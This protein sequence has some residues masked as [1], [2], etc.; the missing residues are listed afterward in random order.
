V[1]FY[2]VLAGVDSNL[3]GSKA[4]P[5]TVTNGRVAFGASLDVAKKLPKNPGSWNDGIE[6]VRKDIVNIATFNPVLTGA[7]LGL[8]GGPVG[9]A[10]GAT[11]GL[12]IVGIDKLT[13]G[14]ATKLLQAG[15]KNVR[16]NY[17]FVRDVADKN[18]GMGLLTG[19][20]MIAG[21]VLG[22]LVG[23]IAGPEGTAIGAAFGVGLTG[24][25]ER[26]LFES[27]AGADISKTLNKS[28]KFAGTEA[29]QVKYNFGR[30][31]TR[32]VLAKVPGWN[33]LGD[34]TKGIG[35]VTSGAL[36]FGF[37]VTL[38][39]D[40][41]AGKGVGL[42]ARKTMIRPITEPMT[43]LTRAV[44]SESE[45]S[46]V[47]QR[48]MADVDMIKRT[49][50]GEQTPYT[51]VF[52][53]YQE[54]KPHELASRKE[55]DSEIGQVAAQLFAGKSTEEIGLLARVGRGDVEAVSEMAQKHADT[56]AEMARY[57]D[58]L[59]AVDKDGIINFQY[60]GNLIP[61][62]KRFQENYDMVQAEMDSL[63]AKTKW[64]GD[65]LELEGAM[66]NRTVSRWAW[67]ER[68]RN[69][70]AKE[71]AAR[72]VSGTAD[73][74]PE[75]GIGKSYQWAYQKSPFSAFIR[76]VD[77]VTQDAPN[78]VVNFNDTVIANERVAASLRQAE[79]V[80]A[81]IPENNLRIFDK[82][83]RATNESEK[84]AIL[85]EYTATGFKM[86]G[87]KHGIAPMLID[88]AIK[89]Y[90][91]NHRLFQS[92][93]MKA[94]NMKKGYMNDPQNPNTLISDPQL[95]TQLANGAM[96]MDWELADKALKEFKDHH[97]AAATIP[98]RV[99]DSSRIMA[100]EL[101]GLWR[102]FT[103]LRTGYPVNVIKDAH[104]RAWGDAALFDVW[105]YLGQDAIDAVTNSS[106]TINRVNRWAVGKID[107]NKNMQY[108]REEITARQNTL[109]ILGGY[110]KKAGL[111]VN[112][113]P[114]K[115]PAKFIEDLENYN[116]IQA[117]LDGLRVHE[118][119]IVKGIKP[120][121]V[122]RQTI[123]ID[124]ETFEA[125]GAG[126]FGQ[127]FMSKITQKDDL[128]RAMSSI[129]ELAI[130]NA[131]RGRSGTRTVLPTDE[132]LHL[133]SWEQILNDKIRF[134]PVAR[135]IMDNTSDVTIVKWLKSPEGFDYM[136]R[137]AAKR[138]DAPEIYDR[139][140]A[141]V[142]MYAPSQAMRKL[143]MEDKMSAVELKKLYP[144]INER[145]PVY[146]DMADDMLGTSGF[147]KEGRQKIKDAIATLSTWPTSKL[148][149]S[150]YFRAKYEQQLQSQIW[151]ANAQDK[152]LTIADKARFE[153]R[154][155]EFAL[156]EYREKLNSFHRDMNYSGVTNYLLAFFPA[157][158]E[159]FRAYGRIT[160]EHPEFAI[161]KLKF[162]ATPEQISDV[163]T[164]P[165]GN[166]Y[167]EVDLPYFGLKSRI[168]T[169]W[170]N[171]D[172]PTG[173]DLISIHPFAG[174]A[175][176]EFV[177]RSHIENRF[178]DMVLP[179]GVQSN[180]LNAATPNTI[181]R[182]SQVFSAGFSKD[183]EQFNKDVKMFDDQL[184][185]EFS[186]THDG[187]QP[188]SSDWADIHRQAQKNAFY[189]SVLRF[190]SASTLP[191]QGRIVTGITQYSDLFQEYQNKFGQQA[192]EMFAQDHPEYFM[193]ADKLTDPIS[194][195]HPDKT[196]AALVRRHMDSVLNVV[197]GIG[198]NG[199]L[200]TL[201]AIFNDD[202]YAFSAEAETYLR[203]TKIPGTNKK[204]RDVAEAFGQGRASIV[205][206]G[207]NDFFKV[208]EVVAEELKKSN[209]PV[210][211]SGTYGQQI[212]KRY[213][214]AFV[215]T[216]KTANP[217]WFDEYTSQ[218]K[219][220]SGSRQAD[221]VK[222]LTIAIEDDKLWKDLSKQPKWELILDYMQYRYNVT[223]KLKAMGTTIDS[224]KAY[225][226]RNE[227]NSTIE[228]MRKQN[229]EF[230]KF[231]DRYFSNDKFDYVYEGQ[232]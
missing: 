77:R 166:Q 14:G 35:A 190:F 44:F 126:R 50:A 65:G 226:L 78:G 61:L 98:M 33:T 128:R 180:S 193:L 10:V 94:Q 8:T 73:F 20:T 31:I 196:S 188:S 225:G 132:A 215:E 6:T 212:V 41:A 214:Q 138:S 231:Y 54:A 145:P 232:Q 17:A 123:T 137:F 74:V 88:D 83:T 216:Q 39:M 156:R 133:Q 229:T 62:S 59:A 186:K 131:R 122:G 13:N 167:F 112:N 169:S 161:R 181:R 27:G 154:A 177:K 176:N 107:K 96:L 189:T 114:K 102:S 142:D 183:G 221:T 90:I 21:G 66:T 48:L 36:N 201:G 164:D 204:F 47:G 143:I 76:G 198:P 125:A 110:L 53:F 159:Q 160:L 26:N 124:G 52:K 3:G 227:V 46:R 72:R 97:G 7:V 127:I 135:M 58:A 208:K 75:T 192:T 70:F 11:A 2:D 29:G 199:D 37:E 207:W 119:T 230:S 120:N 175:V 148:A 5:S 168:P 67:A 92:E 89:S 205:G 63:R 222:A 157:L 134:D 220:G 113:L 121:K 95:I 152:V 172:N 9:A 55:F 23:T 141:V 217:M 108:L 165:F 163:K 200:T 79:K 223:N 82:W 49:V 45:A 28:A 117:N 129:K 111:D 147:Y 34:T 109:N 203:D 12:G 211:P 202:N 80:K 38:G 18:L 105:K 93:A 19:L 57:Q 139:V 30:D 22:G 81:S 99:A 184:R 195:M 4:L 69:D 32:D 158:V 25:L 71:N 171:P 187:V 130:E 153:R 104:I 150:P 16:S 151:V 51:P 162:A 178:T 206:K 42:A 40:M 15:A 185:F 209:P 24:K 146:S 60:K 64:L 56:F 86:L 136:D 1:S 213:T 149:F 116:T 85:E 87:K 115:I 106:N 191:V 103:L 101:N 179:F 100:D 210:D 219:G 170:F 91:E 224:A 182:L 197:S 155:R 118:N 228:A 140:K 174:A 173:G 194:G 218:S 84:N 43:G 68:V 144:N